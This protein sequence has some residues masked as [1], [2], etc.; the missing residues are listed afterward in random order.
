[1]VDWGILTRFEDH[2]QCRRAHDAFC[3][4]ALQDDRMQSVFAR[5]CLGKQTC[6]LAGLRAFAGSQ[7]S[8]L[9][10]DAAARFFIQYQC[11]QSPE[12]LERKLSSASISIYIEIASAFLI[13]IFAIFS[14]R[15]TRDLAKRYDLKNV[16]PCDYSLF[17][18]LSEEQQ[19]EFNEFYN[20]RSTVARG[21]Q[22]KEWLGKKMYLF[23]PDSQVNIMKVDLVFDNRKMLQLL[24]ARGQAISIKETKTIREIEEEIQRSIP[25]QYSTNIVGA[26]VMFEN[27]H[28]VRTAIQTS[29][30]DKAC[31][32]HR[33]AEP[34]DYIWENLAISPQ[35]RST[36][37]AKAGLW[38]LIILLIAYFYQFKMQAAVASRD[39]YE[40]IDCSLYADA[41]SGIASAELAQVHYQQQ[42]FQTW[43]NYYQDDDDAGEGTQRN[44]VN[45]TLGCFCNDQYDEIG[46][47]AAF[48]LFRQD[49]RNA[50]GASSADGVDE[51]PICQTYVLQQKFNESFYWLLS[52]SIIILNTIFYWIIIPLVET[53][54]YQRRTAENR[55][56]C[57]L[58]IACYFMDMVLLPIVIGS[59]FTEVSE[60]RAA[61]SFFTG[62]Y[63][64]FEAGW[65]VD[66]GNQIC[67]NMTL[68]A[69]QPLIDFIMESL[70]AVAYR[71]YCRKYVYKVAAEDDDVSEARDYLSFLDL[72]AG[73]EYF[74]YYKCAL[75]NLIV[76]T[77]ILFGGSMPVLYFIG[78]VAVALQYLFER[79]ALTFFYRLPPKY[80][81]SLT[82][83]TIA[84]IGY[85][86]VCALAILF[87]QHTNMQMFD[88]KIDKLT[89][90]NQ[91]RRSHHFLS[92]IEWHK[93][94]HA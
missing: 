46:L 14:K 34:S 67:F 72:H 59:N 27:I 22:F 5:D 64:D 51:E 76:L 37:K 28:Q 32:A 57:L 89:T 50:S 80:S 88:N 52:V 60:G 2:F 48:K 21:A 10:R 44:Y 56:S 84:L 86:P 9:C 77:C 24:K 87:W 36:N 17:I 20:E 81:E 53:I 65:Y 63:G 68:F 58:I 93:L 4:S 79:W 11:K 91:V 85:A 42:A 30:A 3:N 25:Q 54:G 33:S 66:I 55:V 82:L 45:G 70:W 61:H 1:M 47:K 6:T 35:Q 40:Q 94:N 31:H 74:F 12:D 16:T 75:T 78:L 29:R 8:Q 23:S 26:F 7:G 62:T 92:S 73:P 41:R 38:L 19:A 43:K 49:G 71:W 13:T 18:Q 39:V 15:W 69:L 90:Q 83:T